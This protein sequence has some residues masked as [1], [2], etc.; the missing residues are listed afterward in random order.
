VTPSPG[1][2]A[3][4]TA[5]RILV[6]DDDRDWVVLVELAL[7]FEGFEVISAAS[8]EEALVHI[9]KEEPDAILLDIA[10]PG[11]DGWELLQRLAES[12]RATRIPV[13]VVSGR[14]GRD[15]TT[16]VAELGGHGYV[17]KPCHTS[18]LVRAVRKACRIP[19]QPP[20]RAS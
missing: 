14:A 3:Q 20:P 19:P 10:L 2:G 5:P 15:A 12:G 18:M 9:N 1:P 8:G 4:R 6:V 16:R 7:T 11:I 17:P 13:V